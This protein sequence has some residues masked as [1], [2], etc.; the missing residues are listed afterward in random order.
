VEL[1]G[2]VDAFAAGIVSADARRPIAGP[3][4]TGRTYQA[5]IGQ[6]T[7]RDTIILALSSWNTPSGPFNMGGE[8]RGSAHH[9]RSVAG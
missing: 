3:S 2:F 4:R 8:V 5:G 9:C 7:E 1:G 6:H